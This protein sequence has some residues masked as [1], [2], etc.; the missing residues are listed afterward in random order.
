[1]SE[2]DVPFTDQEVDTDEPTK[3]VMSIFALIVG[4]GIFAMAQRAGA[5]LFG[6][7][8]SVVS[9]V[10]GYGLDGSGDSGPDVI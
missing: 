4:F 10:T 9:N 5:N 7:A 8:N 6:K 3:A 1:M 2:V